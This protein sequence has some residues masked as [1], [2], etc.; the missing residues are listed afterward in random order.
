VS[1]SFTIDPNVRVRG[2]QTYADISDA[3]GVMPGIG[4]RV[5]A[6]EP[7]SGT[8]W[9]AVVTTV[10]LPKGLVY[11]LVAWDEGTRGQV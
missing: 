10:D 5:E 11:L 4:E 1:L 2:D 8:T 6:R 3:H 9:P 7:E